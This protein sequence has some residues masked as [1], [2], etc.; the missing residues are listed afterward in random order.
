MR[1]DAVNHWE[2]VLLVLAFL[3]SWSLFSAAQNQIEEAITN[4]SFAPKQ[5]CKDT[6]KAVCDTALIHWQKLWRDNKDT[7]PQIAGGV[8]YDV[9]KHLETPCWDLPPWVLLI[10]LLAVLLIGPYLFARMWGLVQKRLYQNW[11]RPL[12]NPRPLWVFPCLYFLIAVGLLLMYSVEPWIV[13]NKAKILQ[14]GLENGEFTG[15]DYTNY[16]NVDKYAKL[17]E[18]QVKSVFGGVGAMLFA[19]EMFTWHRFRS[20]LERIKAWVWLMLCLLLVTCVIVLGSDTGTNRTSAISLQ[21]LGSITTADLARMLLLLTALR[22]FVQRNALELLDRYADV[23]KDGRVM[24]LLRNKFLI[25]SLF[26]IVALVLWASSNQY[27]WLKAL[28]GMVFLVTS[29]FVG[30]RS[31]W[32]IQLLFLTAATL[33]ACG[34]W[35]LT[36]DYGAI[37]VILPV[38]VL[39]SLFRIRH[40]LIAFA[41]IAAIIG[42]AEL[43]YSLDYNLGL[44]NYRLVERIEHVRDPFH[45]APFS[46]SRAANSDVPAR[47]LWAAREAG[48]FRL[49]LGDNQRIAAIPEIDTD[50]TFAFF[51]SSS[52][53]FGA[54]LVLLAYMG[55][56]VSL[57][58]IASRQRIHEHA[59]WTVLGV[60]LLLAWQTALNIG[61]TLS[62]FPLTGIPL[63]FIGRGT[64]SMLVNG[65]LLGLVLGYRDGRYSGRVITKPVAYGASYGQ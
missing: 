59:F 54:S 35:V 18:G 26:A 52:G 61:A 41:T 46:H 63:T 33:L 11:R 2:W 38:L 60:T 43:L 30:F 28:I 65:F 50:L 47:I 13:L 29:L 42:G 27:A 4:G 57:A 10:L 19:Q 6:E 17:F 20:S 55:L 34:A 14:Q 21:A 56:F 15:K 49:K 40:P 39:L 53:L 25:V 3:L 31:Q 37:L 23:T 8:S 1:T 48:L 36:R 9:H 7:P 44:L 5:L 45:G 62:I 16:L 22:F 12:R 51:L 58:S 64:V 24:T 32:W